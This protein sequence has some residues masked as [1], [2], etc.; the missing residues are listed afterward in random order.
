VESKVTVPGL[1]GVVT[2]RRECAAYQRWCVVY[3]HYKPAAKL[4]GTGEPLPLRHQGAGELKQPN[5]AMATAWAAL[6]NCSVRTA[7][8]RVTHPTIPTHVPG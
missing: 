3:Q 7:P 8:S 5:R 6:D 4:P 1:G 2:L